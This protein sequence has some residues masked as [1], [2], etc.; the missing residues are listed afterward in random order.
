MRL[1]INASINYTGGGLNIAVSI[2]EEC[3]KTE[4]NSYIIIAS[5]NV[6]SSINVNISENIKNV[7]IIKSPILKFYQYQSYLSSIENEYNPDIVFSVF[8]PVYWRPKSYH[9]VGYAMGHYIYPESPY[10]KVVGIKEKLK[11]KIKKLLHFYYLN[12]DADQFF[13]E[14]EDVAKRLQSIFKK[15]CHVVSNTCNEYF[16]NFKVGNNIEYSNEELCDDNFSLIYPCTPYPHKN[17]SIIPKVLDILFEKKIF[18]IKFVVTMSDEKYSSIIPVN[19]R[20]NVVNIGTVK[21]HQLP[22]A[23]SKASAVFVPTLLECFTANYPEGMIM[24]KPILTSDL[25]FAHS[26]CNDAALYFS[27]LD[28]IDIANKIML[29]ISNKQL[30]NQLVSNGYSRLSIFLTT[31]ERVKKYIDILQ[32][33]I[34]NI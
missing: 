34:K 4:C 1:L 7:K 16:Y 30:Y 6:Y 11:W 21:P 31:R 26:I 8:G 20:T 13:V 15:K 14:T 10:W 23:Y 12:R 22:I 19:Y 24:G 27:P 32:S 33:N 17:L 3:L 9:I 5:P 18:N 28:P 29:L 25:P 2:I